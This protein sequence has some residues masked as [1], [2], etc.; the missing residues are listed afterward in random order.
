ME[1]TNFLLRTPSARAYPVSTIIRPVDG[2]P[3]LGYNE[4]P[5]IGTVVVA[6]CLIYT[7]SFA[8]LQGE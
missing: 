5:E 8:A 1:S 6:V 4:H 3:R 7:S 2:I